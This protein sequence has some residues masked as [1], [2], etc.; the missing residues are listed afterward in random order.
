[1][2]YPPFAAQPNIGSGRVKGGR[3]NYTGIPNI[4]RSCLTSAS[5]RGRL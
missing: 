4:I 1:M 3:L 2:P 5:D